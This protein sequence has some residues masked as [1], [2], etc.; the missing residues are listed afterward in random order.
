[1]SNT[2]RREMLLSLTSI[3]VT[4]LLD[5]L[6]QQAQAETPRELKR[7]EEELRTIYLLQNAR[8]QYPLPQG[9][10]VIDS[11]SGGRDFGATRWRHGKRERHNGIDLFV[12]QGTDVYP[13]IQGK[14][15]SVTRERYAGKFV[16]VESLYPFKFKKSSPIEDAI[17]YTDYMHLQTQTVRPGQSAQFNTILGKVGRTGVHVS[18]PHLHV[19][20]YTKR[21]GAKIF[22]DPRKALSSGSYYS[23]IESRGKEDVYREEFNRINYPTQYVRTTL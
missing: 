3:I 14:V 23:L 16:T 13:I 19:Q 4:S 5:P 7:K 15:K 21:N 20:M 9:V 1:M 8:T 12:H 17:I 11:V 6:P 2:N 18:G 10:H 22:I